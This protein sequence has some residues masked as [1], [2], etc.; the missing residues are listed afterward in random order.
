MSGRVQM[1]S[2]GST[3]DC[4]G[5]GLLHPMVH[6][7]VEMDGYTSCTCGPTKTTMPQ[8]FL[9][10][11]STC[12]LTA[13]HVCSDGS[14]H[15]TVEGK[16]GTANLH[17]PFCGGLLRELSCKLL[18]K[19]LGS[20]R[21]VTLRNFV[22]SRYEDKVVLHFQTDGYA[23]LCAGDLADGA[24]VQIPYCGGV[25]G[26]HQACNLLSA[27]GLPCRVINAW[28]HDPV[29]CESYGSMYALPCTVESDLTMDGILREQ[30]FVA[31]ATSPVMWSL[32][33]LLDGNVCALS[34]PCQTFSTA[35]GGAGWNSSAGWIF[36]DVIELCAA[37][38]LKIR[39]L[40]N[41]ATVSEKQIYR[42]R[43]EHILHSFGFVLA[44]SWVTQLGHVS[45]I[46][47]RRFLGVAVKAG[48]TLPTP[49]CG[50]GPNAFPCP[51]AM[52]GS[53]ICLM[54]CSCKPCCQ[55]TCFVCVTTPPFFPGKNGMCNPLQ[56][57]NVGQ[58]DVLPSTVAMASY[59]RQHLKSVAQLSSKGL[60]GS[61]RL[62]NNKWAFF[63]GLELWV[64]V[65]AFPYPGAMS[66]RAMWLATAL[67]ALRPLFAAV[68]LCLGTCGL[69]V[70]F[71]FHQVIK[72]W[73]SQRARAT[74]C[75]IT[76]SEQDCCSPAP[77]CDTTRFQRIALYLGF[78]AY[79]S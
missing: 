17:V 75:S 71:P 68:V 14:R 72:F 37:V 69:H 65:D 49:T 57:R 18:E 25:C 12:M 58:D 48:M 52:P 1:V 36:E 38:D 77:G 78:C 41:V 59:S 55:I 9:S 5:F 50:Q 70:R 26:W 2:R 60:L 19:A 73:E 56:G 40:E 27:M 63:T 15:F 61:L 64:G 44:Y 22:L 29:A 7:D 28:D 62:R 76:F 54:S 34:W 74:D 23:L 35:G 42:D 67:H 21:K 3:D 24:V 33:S 45:P 11:Q 79:C 43:L 20:A 32:S 13:S 4:A 10:K 6:S 47:R 46:L 16:F 30:V 51:S 39:V 31:E 53:M 66:C 8:R